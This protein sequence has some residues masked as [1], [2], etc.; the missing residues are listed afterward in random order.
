MYYIQKE[1]CLE[2]NVYIQVLLPEDLRSR[3]ETH[4]HKAELLELVLDLGRIPIARFPDGDVPLRRAST[5]GARAEPRSAAGLRLPDRPACP[6]LRR[7]ASALTR[8][9][10]DA[11]VG[12]CS[13]FGADNRAGIDRTLHRISAIR[14]RARAIVGLTCRVGRAVGGSAELVR[15]IVM[16]GASVLLLGRPGVGKT[17]AIREISRMLSDEGLRRVVLVRPWGH[18]LPTHFDVELHYDSGDRLD[19]RIK[20]VTPELRTALHQLGCETGNDWGPW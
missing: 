20:H 18:V 7:S 8:Q 19:A 15:D 14:N 10:L 11:A 3:V 5:R 16:S 2:F 9:Q 13:E 6:P 1:I 12:R 4:P 17:T